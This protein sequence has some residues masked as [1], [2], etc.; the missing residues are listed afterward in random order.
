MELLRRLGGEAVGEGLLG[1]Q[2]REHTGHGAGEIRVQRTKAGQNI[3]ADAVAG[4]VVGEVGAVGAVGLPQSS[5]VVLDL[6][7][8]AVQQGADDIAADAGDATKA[9]QSGAPH[10]VHQHRFDGVIK[11]VGG[12]DASPLLCRLGKK[13]VACHPTGLLHRDMIP[14]RKGGGIDA[15]NGTGQPQLLRQ[16]PHKAFIPVSLCAAQPVVDMADDQIPAELRPQGRQ[17]AQ[18][19]D[20]IRAAGN[21]DS[22]PVAL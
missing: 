15:G 9:P 21:P 7:T 4:V 2:P 17:K 1:G 12:G 3:V 14:Q 20:R 10:Q 13:G 16:R 6:G 5:Q 18:K 8:G 11:G 19:S 22:D